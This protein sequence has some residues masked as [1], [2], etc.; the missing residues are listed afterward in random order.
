M[1][2]CWVFGDCLEHLND[3]WQ[4]LRWVHAHQPDRGVICACP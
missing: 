2:E 1:A 4:V 3:P